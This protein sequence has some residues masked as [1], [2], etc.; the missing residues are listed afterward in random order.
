MP[1]LVALRHRTAYH[2]D[3]PLALGPQTVRLRPA[4]HARTPVPSYSLAVLPLPHARHLSQDPQGN[5]LE[6]VLFAEPTASFQLTVELE[7]ELAEINPFDFFLEPEGAT[8]PFRYPP[9]SCPI[10]RTEDAF[11]RPP[12]GC[13]GRWQRCRRAGQETGPLDVG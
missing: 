11:F 7:A 12:L 5:F 6:R 10:S 13:V 2:Y 9:L 1:T 3:R 8:W 4:P